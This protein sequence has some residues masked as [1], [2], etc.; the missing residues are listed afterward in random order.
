MFNPFNLD[1]NIM[2]TFSFFIKYT[3]PAFFVLHYNRLFVIILLISISA[4]SYVTISGLKDQLKELDT[5]KTSVQVDGTT[6]K[7]QTV[8]ELV[9]QLN[10]S[11]F[12]VV[13]KQALL[14]DMEKRFP[15]ISKPVANEII[16]TVMSESKKYNINPLMLYSMGTVE[17]TQRFW[18]E[19]SQCRIL[20]P[21]DDGKGTKYVFAKAVGWGG[22]MWEQ[23]KVFLMKKGIAQTRSDLFI[24]SVNIKATAAIYNMYFE[25]DKK[26]QARTQEE[27]AQLRYFG[28]CFKSYADRIHKQEG[29]VISSIIDRKTKN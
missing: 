15:Y 21:R 19:H 27:S 16:D 17:S 6:R 7:I 14:N 22:V 26:P 3:L 25:L 28:G 18:I 13:S 2:K 5:L 20:V 4:Y 9:K 12:I 24:P 8:N 23:H 11:S 1:K 10:G 29:I